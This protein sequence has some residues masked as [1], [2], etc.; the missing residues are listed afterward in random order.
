MV[1]GVPNLEIG[2]TLPIGKEGSL[3]VEKSAAPL[4]IALK[5]LIYNVHF[6]GNEERY[7]I[8]YFIHIL[9]QLLAILKIFHITVPQYRACIY[10]LFVK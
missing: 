5:R 3:N 9:K 1:W 4:K 2:Q 7:I 10:N 6:T 8:F